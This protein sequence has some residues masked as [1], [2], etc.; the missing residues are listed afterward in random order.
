VIV[1][2][3][4]ALFIGLGSFFAISSFAGGLSE[5]IS[6]FL[7]TGVSLFFNYLILLTPVFCAVLPLM[8]ISGRTE[9]TEL[10]IYGSLYGVVLM[11]V[12]IQT[13]LYEF[14]LNAFTEHYGASVIGTI[15]GYLMAFLF[16]L[17]GAVLWIL[18][19]S[20]LSISKITGILH[21]KVRRLRRKRRK[22]K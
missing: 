2:I 6:Q 8:I 13:G 20:L 12:V 18:D 17:Y 7:V 3:I 5:G 21:K 14:I 1:G 10:L 15:S 16:W 11:F 9:K 19:Y 22:K 4:L